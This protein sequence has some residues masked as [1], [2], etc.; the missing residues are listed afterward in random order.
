MK[1]EFK[2]FVCMI[3]FDIFARKKSA[4]FERVYI[5]KIYDIEEK[6]IN[7][8]THSISYIANNTHLHVVVV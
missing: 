4:P 1:A 2:Y 8:H 6:H 7:T 3:I 5:E